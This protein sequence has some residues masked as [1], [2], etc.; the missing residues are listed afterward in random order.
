MKLVTLGDDFGS[1]AP[2]VPASGCKSC[3]KQSPV[4]ITIT[5]SAN[6]NTASGNANNQFDNKQHTTFT[7]TD[8]HSSARTGARPVRGGMS[9]PVQVREEVPSQS[10]NYVKSMLTKIVDKLN[11]PRPEPSVIH[12]EKRTEKPKILIKERRVNVPIEH[13]VNYVRPT[14]IDQVR[15]R[16]VPYIK[17]VTENRMLDRKVPYVKEVTETIPTDRI[18]TQIIERENPTVRER[19][20]NKYLV[21][22]AN[23]PAPPP[24]FM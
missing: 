23:Q 5:N 18:K 14:T 8:T 15:E 3:G 16:Q 1:F 4:N 7:Q 12:H 21:V 22:R 6:G 24:S 20:K 2:I 19:I 17:D 13:R 11:A 9:A 10:N